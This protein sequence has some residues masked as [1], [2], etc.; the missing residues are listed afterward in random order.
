MTGSGEGHFTWA[1]RETTGR[2]SS[3]VIRAVGRDNGILQE[4]VCK[5]PLSP[6]FV[7]L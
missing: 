4:S 5:L 2:V 6:V 7:K 3:F 1:G